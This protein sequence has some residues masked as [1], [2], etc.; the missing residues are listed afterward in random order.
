M[1][2]L[3]LFCGPPGAGKTTLARRLSAQGAGVRL[4]TD[5]WVA[6]LGMDSL[7]G[8]VHDRLQALLY[9]HALDLLGTG[10]DVIL[11]DGLWTRVER[12]QKFAD[13]HAVG[14]RL[15]WHVFE[16]EPAE[17]ARRVAL[18]NESPQRR[19]PLI[20]PEHL[21]RALAVFEPP[22]PDELAQVDEWE[23]HR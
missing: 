7:V 13:A 5:E 11:E 21:T 2:T 23:V 16:V 6:D 14:A 3:T 12:A 22:T 9:R 10:V 19:G 17:L 1:A 18:R 8:D 15:S 4:C 20:T